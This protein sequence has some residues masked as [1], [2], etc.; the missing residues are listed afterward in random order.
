MR[1]ESQL[2][3]RIMERMSTV[4]RNASARIVELSTL[5]ANNRIHAEILRLGLEKGV[6]KDGKIYITPVPVH[7]EIAS[8]VSTARET[9]A[10]AMN[11]LAR[12]KIVTREKR[13]LVIH[14]I[15]KLSDMVQDVRGTDL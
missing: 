15:K 7:N 1:E 4:I 8:R 2:A 14:D 5:G 11:D 10:R 13:T 3:M 6:E 12:K 9:V